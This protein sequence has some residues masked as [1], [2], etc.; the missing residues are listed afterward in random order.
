MS[1]TPTP[2]HEQ[3]ARDLIKAGAAVDQ[4]EEDGWTALMFAC[5]NGHVEV[6]AAVITPSAITPI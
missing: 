3:V 2:H 1:V 4:V 5:L 6:R